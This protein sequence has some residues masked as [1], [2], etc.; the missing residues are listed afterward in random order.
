MNIE[1]KSPNSAAP[2]LL[3]RLRDAIRIRNYS[4]R[5]AQ[6]YAFWVRK[7]ILFQGKR[8]PEAMRAAEVKAFLT[9]LAL[10]RKV[11]ASTQNQALGALLFLYRFVLGREFEAADEF[12]RAKRHYRIPVVLSPR[13][14]A[15]IAG[16]LQ[17]RA[18]LATVLMYG[19][20]LRLLEC[21][22]LRVQDIDF[23]RGAIVVRQGKGQKDRLT[24]LPDRAV[25]LLRAHLAQFQHQ[26]TREVWRAGDSL[27]SKSRCC[28]ASRARPP[29]GPGN[30]YFQHLASTGRA[31]GRLT[32][33]IFTRARCRE[34]SRKQSAS[35]ES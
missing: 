28:G 8:H 24:L 6:A 1:P 23:E 31:A 32:A 10:T 22:R 13:E 5:T 21:L 17:G 7:F 11:A 18:Y 20:G 4:D 2:R 34:P 16:Q 25:P 14:I 35:R 26:H 19:S 30:G 29:T 12:V 3:D 33:A 15:A 27:S 9:Y